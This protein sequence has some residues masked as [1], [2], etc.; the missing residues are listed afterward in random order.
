MI[1]RRLAFYSIALLVSCYSFTTATAQTQ[2]AA[3]EWPGWGGPTRQFVSSAT[4]LANTWPAGGPKKL[5]SRPLGEG[6]STIVVDNGRLYTIY[7]PSTGVRNQFKAEEVVIALD[8]ASGQT[9]WQHTY[10]AP[11]AGMDFSRGAGPHVTPLIVGSRLFAAGTNKQF[12]ALDKGT[13]KVL[14]AHDFVKE[15][16]APANIVKYP[17]RPGY[18]SSPLAYR[19][20]IIA[21][22]GGAGHGVMAFRQDNGEVVWRAGTFSD[23]AQASPLLI[24][25][26][27]QDQ[28]VVTS[29]DGVHGLDPATGAP[30]WGPVANDPQQGV[31]ISTPVWSEADRLLFF[32]AAYAGGSKVLELSRSGNTTDVKELWFNK[33]MR[34]HFSNVLRIGNVYVGSSG[35]SGPS[36]LTAIDARTGEVAW[37]DRTFRK[38]SMVQADGK[39]LLLDEDGTLALLSVSP[40]SVKV[41]SQASVA[42]A[43][44]WTAPTLVKTTL[45]VRDR[46]NIMAFD[47]GQANSD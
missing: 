5:W 18:A 4:G 1:I 10:A 38:A 41:L 14:W 17:V 12:F 32:T 45:Y 42:A 40:E 37:Q 36:F 30:L 11:I 7:R 20:T 28:L 21:M 44:S 43:T 3:P 16:G 33:R 9:L 31:H 24:N 26:Q 35:D 8:A 2:Q 19:D 6:H 15:Y 39:V 34:V 13:G 22:V 46:V 29:N 47:L 27:G 25:V 23:I